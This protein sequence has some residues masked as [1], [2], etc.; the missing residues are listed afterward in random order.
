MKKFN[1]KYSAIILSS[2]YG[3]DEKY[4]IKYLK[5][6]SEICKSVKYQYSVL[7][8][9]VFEKIEEK[10]K[11]SIEKKIES[12][13]IEIKALLLINNDGK[14]FA[15][16]LNYGIKNTNSEFIFRLDTDDRTNQKRIINQ[17]EIMISQELI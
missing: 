7:P 16:C 2:S 11:L 14:G 10:K 1:N 3:E 15:S 12:Q 9:L 8:V 4:L 17:L 6:V 5:H 13:K